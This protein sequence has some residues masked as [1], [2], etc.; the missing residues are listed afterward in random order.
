ME[1]D[2]AGLSPQD[3][4]QGHLS[5]QRT[6]HSIFRRDTSFGKT[7]KKCHF[8]LKLET[9]IYLSPVPSFPHFNPQILLFS[10]MEQRHL[11]SS[12]MLTTHQENCLQV[13]RYL[14]YAMPTALDWVECGPHD[15]TSPPSHPFTPSE[16]EWV[17]GCAP[18]KTMQQSQ[19]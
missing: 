11:E 19:Q 8:F 4:H 6:G 7:K 13:R 2:P 14:T 3:G 15:P 1:V 5:C 18:N 17:L 16:C 12:H 10:Q 9:L